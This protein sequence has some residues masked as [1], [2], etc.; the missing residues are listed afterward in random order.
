[1]FNDM[2]QSRCPMLLY[3]LLYGCTWKKKNA[4]HSKCATKTCDYEQCI[5]FVL[6]ERSAAVTKGVVGP[7][8]NTSTVPL[9]EGKPWK[10]H[11]NK[12]KKEKIRRT[13]NS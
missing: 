11:N 8:V 3:F 12:N 5:N 6:Q 1:M 2:D 4:Q 13:V 7:Q 9:S 10:K